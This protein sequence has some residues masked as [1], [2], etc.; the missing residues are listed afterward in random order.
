[1]KIDLREC[2]DNRFNTGAMTPET[3]NEAIFV[4]SAIKKNLQLKKLT[5]KT[6][7]YDIAIECYEKMMNQTDI[8]SMHDVFSTGDTDIGSDG[9]EKW[10]L[11]TYFEANIG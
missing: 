10:G 2:V 11:M 5:D 7:E 8:S 6:D 1:M 3:F 4:C 9:S